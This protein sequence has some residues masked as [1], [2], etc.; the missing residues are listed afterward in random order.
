MRT[1]IV[2]LL[3]GFVLAFLVLALS[4]QPA[5]ERAYKRRNVSPTNSPEYKIFFMFLVVFPILTIVLAAIALVL[6]S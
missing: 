2:S 6:L 5:K 3:I 4:Y 1:A